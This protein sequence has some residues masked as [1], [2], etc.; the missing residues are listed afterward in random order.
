MFKGS[1][2]GFGDAAGKLLNGDFKGALGALK[3]NKFLNNLIGGA[4]MEMFNTPQGSNAVA[5]LL[6]GDPTG[7]WHLTVGNPLNPIMVVGNL[8]MQD[9]NITFSGGMGI[10][11]FP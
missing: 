9:C 2:D 3:G 11:D 6:T 8:C 10:Q 4:A 5:S 1:G 7:Q